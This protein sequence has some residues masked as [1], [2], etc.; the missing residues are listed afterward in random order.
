MGTSCDIAIGTW[1][2]HL[3]GLL[4]WIFGAVMTAVVAA[5]VRGGGGKRTRRPVITQIKQILPACAPPERALMC[6]SACLALTS[7]FIASS[8]LA[9]LG[10]IT[11]ISIGPARARVEQ[12]DV[13]RVAPLPRGLVVSPVASPFGLN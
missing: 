5:V 6:M 4:R 10:L 8:A 3:H 1:Y 11:Y 2:Q 13:W 7:H 9:L 12:C